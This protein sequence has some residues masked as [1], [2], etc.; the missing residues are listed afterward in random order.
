MSKLEI[1]SGMFCLL[2]I[3]FL[4]F[5]QKEY[6]DKLL[7]KY[8]P[9]YL[10]AEVG[11]LCFFAGKLVMNE[12]AQKLLFA[13]CCCCFV[14]SALFLCKCGI[15]TKKD[16]KPITKRIV[17]VV[18]GVVS[19]LLSVC[20]VVCDMNFAAYIL[21]LAMIITF[22][23]ELHNKIRM[24]NLTKLYNRYGMDLE[25]KEQLKQYEKDKRD[26][27]Y[28]LS[29][30]LNKFKQINDTWGHAE[31]D[32]ALGLVADVLS[33]VSAMFDSNV[34]RIGGDEFIIITDKSDEGLA[35]VVKEALLCEID[36]IDFRKDF[37][38]S[39]SIGYALYTGEKPIDELFK[40]A[41]ANMYDEKNPEA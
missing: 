18:V 21:I 35:Q 24:D 1:E 2:I 36:K 8:S 31:G 4:Y 22:S 39:M 29:C 40:K 30:D 10:L 28:I 14:V 32:R 6:F 16:I 19:V 20:S 25:L 23:V 41:D 26:S 37:K 27:F 15:E 33:R 38:I 9:V 13:V 7:K 12:F 34:F 5:F 3:A 17:F 11:I